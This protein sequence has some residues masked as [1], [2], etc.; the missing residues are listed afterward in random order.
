M[1]F[2]R[3]MDIGTAKIT[4]DERRGVPHHLLDTLDVTEEA[5]VSD[6][7]IWPAPPLLT[8]RPRKAPHPGRRLGAV[9]PAALDVLEFPGTDPAIR[10]RLEAEL[11]TGGPAPLRAQL[12]RWIRCRPAALGMHAVIRALEV[13]QIT[14]RPFSSFMPNREYVSP[15]YRLASKGTVTSSMSGSSAGSTP[16]WNAG[17]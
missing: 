3:G 4:K 5:S 16:W 13:L 15:R 14:G 2:Y 6:F 12:E 8:S 7:K 17:C 11:Q 1:Q 10:R 9:R